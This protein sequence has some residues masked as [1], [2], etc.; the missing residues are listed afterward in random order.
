MRTPLSLQALSIS[1]TIRWP[2]GEST[3]SGSARRNGSRAQLSLG[4]GV[5]ATCVLVCLAPAAV[6][7]PAFRVEPMQDDALPAYTVADLGTLN[8]S[9]ACTCFFGTSIGDNGHVVGRFSGEADQYHAFLWRDGVMIDIGSLG[10]GLT[11]AQGVNDG[12]MVVGLSLSSSGAE[13]AFAEYD[14]VMVDLG[15]LGGASSVARAVNAD[16]V[17]TGGAQRRRGQQRYQHAAIWVDG[18]AVD[19]GTLGG[20]LSEAFAIND[21]G[22]VVGWAFDRARRQRAFLWTPGRGMIDLGDLGTPTASA[23]AIND[24][25]QVVG[26][27]Q[28][29]GDPFGASHAFRWQ[30]GVMTD[31]GVLPE[32]GHPGPFGP[33]LVNTAA[34]SI[35]DAGQ[36]VGNSY[37]GTVRPGPFLWQDGVM[38]NLNDLIESGSEWTLTEAN[39]INDHGQIV[40]T[41]LSTAGDIRAV[42][43]TPSAP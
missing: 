22:Q 2:L 5:L 13:R 26:F 43:L 40:G 37:P 25:G 27:A 16:G 19:L 39:D 15:T 4:P 28:P 9:P 17:I 23:V 10:G 7:R 34:T 38:R 36:I 33:E 6:A 14:G 8:G 29:A 24:A 42:V 20:E 11:L 31:L 3:F 35:N 41:A 30:N 1:R 18:R 12:G 32:A 21:T